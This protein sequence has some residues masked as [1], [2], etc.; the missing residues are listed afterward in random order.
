LNG[1]SSRGCQT[2]D[3]VAAAYKVFL[4]RLLTWIEQGDHRFALRIDTRQIGSFFQITSLTSESE[5]RERIASAML[6]WPDMFDM[7]WNVRIFF[8]KATVLTPTVGAVTDS[9][10]YAWVH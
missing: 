7:V 1:R 4:P 5:I 8:G 6:F 2:H 9:T 3:E 10:T